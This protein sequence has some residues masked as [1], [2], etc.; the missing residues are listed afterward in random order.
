MAIVQVKKKPDPLPVTL[1]PDGKYAIKN[2]A[3]DFYWCAVFEDTEFLRTSMEFVKNQYFMKWDITNDTNGNISIKTS[4]HRVQSFWVGEETTR[5]KVP[6]SWRLVPADGNFYRLTSDLNDVSQDSRVLAAQL[7]VDQVVDPACPGRIP[8]VMATLKE[9]D[10][11][12]MW[13]F[14][15]L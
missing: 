3:A 2:R 14:I 15:R 6:V 13:E 11:S 4:S 10:E 1:I 5:S 9:G 7:T 8:R 12:Q